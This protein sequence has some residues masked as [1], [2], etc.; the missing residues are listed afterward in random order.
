MEKF[1]GYGQETG[2]LKK[3]HWEDEKN[4]TR[5]PEGSFRKTRN[6]CR[7]FPPPAGS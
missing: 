5:R 1:S 6:V 7:R 2:P 4:S 3:D